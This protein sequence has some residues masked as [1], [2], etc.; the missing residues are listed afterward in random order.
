M[1]TNKSRPNDLIDAF[2]D[3]Y[4]EAMAKCRQAAE[5]TTTDGWQALYADQMDRN[6][7]R[8]AWAADA[9]DT[10]MSELR[11]APFG[12]ESTKALKT[13]VK[14]ALEACESAQMFDAQTVA[15]MREK[16]EALSRIIAHYEHKATEEASRQ[17]LTDAHLPDQLAEAIAGMPKATWNQRVGC[18]TITEGK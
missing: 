12:D 15:P 5:T 2:R 3:E 18:I 16:V 4:G 1:K 14:D 17:P 11:E 6:Q 7:K 13:S 9:I 8:R 10:L